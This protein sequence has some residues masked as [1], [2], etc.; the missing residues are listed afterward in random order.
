MKRVVIIGSGFGG[1]VCALLLGRRGYRVTVL[2]RQRQPGGC[3]QSYRRGGFAF[4]TGLHYIGGLGKG[5][6]LHSL[7]EDLGLLQ[8]PWRRMDAD[9]FDRVTIGSETFSFAQGFSQFADTL[10]QRFPSDRDAL[11]RYAGLLRDLPSV[12][13]IG[14]IAAYKYLAENFSDPLLVNVLAGTSLKTELRRDSLPLFHFAHGQSSYIQS[15][16]RLQ[17]EGS[18]LVQQLLSAI[19]ATG[20]TLYCESEVET[21]TERD[22]RIVAARCSNG[23]SVEGDY[24][25]SDV[26]P[27]VTFSWI[28]ESQVLKKLFRRRITMLPNTYGM[29]T[30]SLVLKPGLLSYFNHNKYIYRQANVWQTPLLFASTADAPQVDRVMVSARVPDNDSPYVRQIDLLTPMPWS[31]CQHWEQTI[32]GRRGSDYQALKQRLAA[33]CISLAEEQLPGLAAAIDCVYTSTPLTY[34]DYTLTPQGSAYGLRHDCRSL[35]LTML[36]P[37]TPISNLLL[38]GQNLILHGV[39]G[40]A[41]TAQRTVSELIAL[42]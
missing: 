6:P 15:S 13:E 22:G 3:L 23:L 19:V 11:Q 28:R 31:L 25:I 9:G 34:R 41:M 17:G 5:Q 37:R 7:F 26:H 32:I 27:A 21:L 1:L 4:D 10:A 42:G 16:W 38:T 20:G 33:A 30:A 39:E 24:F 18:L 29:F 14:E 12:Q 36:S 8:L 2:E 35:L 40:V